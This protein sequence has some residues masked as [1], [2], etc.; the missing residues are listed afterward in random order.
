[1]DI[2]FSRKLIKYNDLDENTFAGKIKLYR[3]T[4]RLTQKKLSKALG[5]DSFTI[6][7]WERGKS[8][9]EP[10]HIPKLIRVTGLHPRP[11]PTNN[12]QRLVYE[13][14]R[15]GLSQRAFAKA[16]GHDPATV[17]RWEKDL[18]EVPEKVWGW[19]SG[20]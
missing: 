13:R 9:P 5:V 12:S 10:R 18:G 16:V 1:V 3:L 14:E 19:I 8:K 2:V 6:L 17:W 20:R 7:N 11:L 4:N 15:L